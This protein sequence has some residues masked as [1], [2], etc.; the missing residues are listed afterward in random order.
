LTDGNLLEKLKN[1]TAM[2]TYEKRLRQRDK[3]L[4]QQLTVFVLYEKLMGLTKQ[5]WQIA[6]DNILDE[7]IAIK[8]LLD[9]LSK[10]DNDE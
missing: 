9:K 3:L 8:K 1:K 10:S 6:V 7:R 4:E 5:Q 2:T